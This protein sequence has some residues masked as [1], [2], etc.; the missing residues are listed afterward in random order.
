MKLLTNLIKNKK[1]KYGSLSIILIV[2]IVV[3][4]IFLNLVAGMFEMKI[5]LTPNKYYSIGEKTEEILEKLDKPV[6]IIGLF[7]DGAVPPGDYTDLLDLLSN[8]EKNKYI[9]IEYIDPDKNPA[10]I[11]QLNPDGL[12]EINKGD[13]IVES[14]G[15]RKV[16]S[17]YDLFPSQLDQRTFQQVRLGSQAEQKITGA[18]KFVTAE[19]TPTLYFL[20][21]HGEGSIDRE[22]VD[23]AGWFE[24][25]NYVVKELDLRTA[26]SV[27]EDAEAVFIASPQRDLIRD[28]FAK[29]RDYLSSMGG[30]AFFFFDSIDTNDKF[31]VFNELLEIY[32]L[33]I[34]HDKIEENDAERLYGDSKFMFAPNIQKT[35]MTGDIDNQNMI[36]LVVNARSVKILK[37]T[38]EWIKTSSLLRTSDK[39]QRLLIG[40]DTKEEGPFDIAAAVDYSGGMKPSKVMVFGSSSFI[41]STTG[42]DPQLDNYNKNYFL[43]AFLW[44]QEEG[45]NIYIPIKKQEV[46]TIQINKATATAIGI[47]VVVVIPLIIIGMGLIVFIRRRHL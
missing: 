17:N 24:N 26:E 23:I 44:T 27:P 43:Q 46:Q 10:I 11:N 7:D 32:N 16:F 30:N 31:T 45:D 42:I 6:K 22:Y 5:D 38:K 28:E 35:S 29:L 47:G 15:K 40:T 37:N 2:F 14:G 1:M 41:D 25:N 18:I 21:G 19:I 39:A 34:G 13:F 33:E 20:T 9:D 36:T 8:Y 4:A 3:I 12:L